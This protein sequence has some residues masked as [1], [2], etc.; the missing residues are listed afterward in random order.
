M[1]P[2]MHINYLPHLLVKDR[3]IRLRVRYLRFCLRF[4]PSLPVFLQDFLRV[5][6]IL[7][8]VFESVLDHLIE[9]LVPLLGL[10]VFRVQD[11]HLF[12][13]ILGRD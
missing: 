11:L 7:G 10:L 8:V 6:I 2:L 1:D 5:L 12:S 3:L 9:L 13:A 4:L